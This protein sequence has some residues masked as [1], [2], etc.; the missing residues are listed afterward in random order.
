MVRKRTLTPIVKERVQFSRSRD[1]ASIR[2]CTSQDPHV[3]P[4]EMVSAR[5]SLSRSRICGTK[6][7]QVNSPLI[8]T[9]QFK[10]G[11]TSSIEKL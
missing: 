2:I 1:W 11:S 8:P 3:I 9:N 5:L 6:R 10:R 4:N 7:T